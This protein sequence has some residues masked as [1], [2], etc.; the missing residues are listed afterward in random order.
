MADQSNPAREQM[1]LFDDVPGA[2]IP[3]R[4]ASKTPA[5]RQSET[6]DAEAAAYRLEETGQYRVLRKLVPRPVVQRSES[7]F[8][9]L[10]VLV[11][12]ET[13]G[14]DHARDEVIEIGAV[15]FTYD[16]DGM[17]GDVVG[18][19]NAF[20]EPS[21]PIPAEVTRLTGITDAMV[22]GHKIDVAALDALVDPADLVIAHNAKFDR[23]FCE[24]LSQSFVPKAW[25]CS[26]SE[27]RWSEMNFEG[28]KLGYLV[29]QAGLFHDGHRAIDDCHA[30][31]AVL[32]RP[33]EGAAPTPFVALLQSS[34]RCRIRVYALNSPFDLKDQLKARGY[35]WSDG[36]DGRPK[37]WWIEVDE[38]LYDDELRYLRTD[39]YRRGEVDPLT[40]R[41]TAHDRF[42]PA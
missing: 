29:G 36:N 21:V 24:R 33:V 9:N 23:A 41:L 1:Q 16:R 14:L 30:L 20:Q 4:P 25:A 18:V 19:Y 28:T 11:D 35:R 2:G 12:T 40:I 3:S 31:L 13:T 27:I 32:S 7:A 37:A 42:R 38:D 5:P 6:W 22:A 26:Q 15:A 8:P 34:M 17:I 10:A 39:I